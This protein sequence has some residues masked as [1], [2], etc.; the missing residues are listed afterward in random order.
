MKSTSG[1]SLGAKPFEAASN[2]QKRIGEDRF[3]TNETFDVV[4]FGQKCIMI[5]QFHA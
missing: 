3:Q 1:D 5:L 2:D 4:S